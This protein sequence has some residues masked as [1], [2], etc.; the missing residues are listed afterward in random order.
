MVEL[1]ETS[2]DSTGCS[3]KV[4]LDSSFFMNCSRHEFK[5]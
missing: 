1:V 5:D 2:E 3:G 4:E